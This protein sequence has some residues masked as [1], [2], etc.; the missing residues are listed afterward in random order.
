M[1]RRCIMMQRCVRIAVVAIVLATSGLGLADCVGDCNG[2]G[3]VTIDEV[4]RGV[5]IV[6]GSTALAE[7]ADLDRNGDST[8]TID[9]V[10]AAVVGALDG[11][12]TAPL[13]VDQSALCFTGM[14]GASIGDQTVTVQR[15]VGAWTAQ[16]AAPWLS[17]TPGSGQAPGELQVS[18]QAASLSDGTYGGEIKLTDSTGK[19]SVIIP[20]GLSLS[21]PGKTT[22]WKL[23]T[24]EPVGA[25]QQ[26][27]PF[28]DPAQTTSLALDPKGRPGITFF[29]TDAA[30]DRQL[31]FA[32]MTG[33]RWVAENVEQMGIESSLAFDSSGQPHISFLKGNGPFPRYAHRVGTTWNVVTV[34]NQGAGGATGYRSSLAL[35]TANHPHISYL[36]KFVT[37][38]V[39]TYDLRYAVFDG[40]A[41][42]LETVDSQGTTGWDSSLA[43]TTTGAPRISY[44]TDLPNVVRVATKG[45]DAWTS[46]SVADG[47]KPSSLRLDSAGRPRIAFNGSPG[48]SARFAYRDD[49][50]WKAETIGTQGFV[51]ARRPF[52]SLAL[53]SAEAPHVAFVDYLNRALKYA[54]RSSDG[55]WTATVIDEGGDV[56]DFC[57]LQIDRQDVAH[58]SYLDLTG[59]L[60]KYAQGPAIP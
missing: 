51:Q 24:V 17:I 16:T 50:G 34:E 54:S 41:W 2:D 5:N 39:F 35:D 7:C 28:A 37:G 42:T 46:E 40:S 12:D 56:G 30:V 15:S 9:E 26:G 19:D 1:S 52:V 14:I 21:M 22:G 31:R 44:H 36:L 10:L 49:A 48:S 33:C 38:N 13:A 18:V 58:I 32:H 20:V 25:A 27:K 43:L 47:G 23:Q 45:A 29:R 3:S 60:L 57:S 55:T 59:G 8:V 4:L 53:D 6:L 11:C